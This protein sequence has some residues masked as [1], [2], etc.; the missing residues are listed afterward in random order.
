MLPGISDDGW[1]GLISS[2]EVTS[3][4]ETRHDRTRHPSKYPV[5]F[6]NEALRL[7]VRVKIN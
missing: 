5:T 4:R 6:I 3:G 1:R 7:G 2:P